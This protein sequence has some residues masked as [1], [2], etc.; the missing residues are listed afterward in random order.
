MELF[1]EDLIT[2]PRW[3][4]EATRDYCPPEVLRCG[5]EPPEAESPAPPRIAAAVPQPTRELPA[6]TGTVSLQQDRQGRFRCDL[7]GGGLK[8]ISSRPQDGYRLRRYQCVG[9]TER[10]TTVEVVVPGGI[11]PHC[12]LDSAVARVMQVFVRRA[13]LPVLERELRRRQEASQ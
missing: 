8:V 7:C 3:N 12:S 13:S 9:C 10:I 11:N 1:R 2:T 5:A 4:G 6:D